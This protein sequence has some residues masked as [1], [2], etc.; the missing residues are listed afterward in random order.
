MGLTGKESTK[1]MRGKE[2]L[3]EDF[4]DED[5]MKRPEGMGG[6]GGGGGGD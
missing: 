6:R 3:W 4:G 2:A 1:K 5:V